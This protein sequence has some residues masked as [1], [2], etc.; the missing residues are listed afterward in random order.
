MSTSAL[1]DPTHFSFPWHGHQNTENFFVSNSVGE[2]QKRD[3]IRWNFKSWGGVS[4]RLV[5]SRS[6]DLL[7]WMIHLSDLDD[8]TTSNELLRSKK[9]GGQ[10]H[11]DRKRVVRFP[12]P[13][14][15]EIQI[16][17]SWGTRLSTSAIL[18]SQQRSI[19]I[20]SKETLQQKT[21]KPIYSSKIWKA[22]YLDYYMKYHWLWNSAYIYASRK[23]RGFKEA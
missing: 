1:L 22:I 23:K 18:F 7:N 13:L 20:T 9:S 8:M 6:F 19:R 16:H 17:V 15:P 14:A 5:A 2:W 4:G 3:E 11:Q 12:N 10:Y 21:F